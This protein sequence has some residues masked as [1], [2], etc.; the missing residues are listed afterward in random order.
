MGEKNGGDS[1]K[2]VEKP[3]E[4]PAAIDQS[5]SLLSEQIIAGRFDFR[6]V[7]RPVVQDIA[8]LPPMSLSD[9][10]GKRVLKVETNV[11]TLNTAIDWQ[12]P[13]FIARGTFVPQSGWNRPFANPTYNFYA[14]TRDESTVFRVSSTNG[15]APSYR[16]E[17]TGQSGFGVLYNRDAAGNT[18]GVTAGDGPVRFGLGHDF[19]KQSTILGVTGQISPYT[20]FGVDASLGGRRDT[21]VKRDY[22]INFYIKI[23]DGR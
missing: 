13:E 4:K 9:D 7:A 10:E 8:Q 5:L 20:R 15:V 23:G 16:F 11:Y 19:R 3:P 6:A 14:Q 12:S 1:Q 2:P 17:H 22:D 18:L 21:G